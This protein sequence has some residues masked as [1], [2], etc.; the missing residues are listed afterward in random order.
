M[1]PLLT[2]TIFFFLIP[3]LVLLLSPYHIQTASSYPFYSYC[4]HHSQRYFTLHGFDFCLCSLINVRSY[5]FTNY[6]IP[7]IQNSAWKSVDHYKFLSEWI[8]ILFSL[9]HCH[10]PYSHPAAILIFIIRKFFA[11]HLTL[12]NFSSLI[13]YNS[14]SENF[15]LYPSQSS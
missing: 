7:S 9:T 12:P 13:T 15:L 8:N 4:T 2:L 6:I 1:K 11:W 14:Y 3:S 5:K 10:L